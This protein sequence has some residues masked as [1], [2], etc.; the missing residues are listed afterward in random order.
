MSNHFI[1]DVQAGEITL[2]LVDLKLLRGDGQAHVGTGHLVWTA[3]GCRLDAVTDGGSIVWGEFGRFGLT[4]GEI[5]PDDHYLALA[6]RTQDGWR[7]SIERLDNGGYEHHVDQESL[8]WR[9]SDR[10]FRSHLIYEQERSHGDET[11]AAFVVIGSGVDLGTWPR[12]SET[13]VENPVFGRSRQQKDWLQFETSFG[14]VAVRMAESDSIQIRARSVKD[15]QMSDA[16]SAIQKALSYVD[17]RRCEYSAFCE[18]DGKTERRWL[19][20]FKDRSR[21]QRIY[22]PFNG[23]AM[24]T[25]CLEPMLSCLCNFFLTEEGKAIYELLDAWMD[26]TENRFTS[27]VMVEC[28]VVEA[29]ARIICENNPAIGS[30]EQPDEVLSAV[31]DL[32]SHLTAMDLSESTQTRLTGLLG[33]VR[34]RSAKDR[35]YAIQ[36]SGWCGIQQDEIKSWNALRNKV[37]HGNSAVGDGSLP[38][39]QKAVDHSAKIANLINKM[40]LQAAGYAG[41][42][43]DYMTWSTEPFQL[44]AFDNIDK[45]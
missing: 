39:F 25:P 11:A 28:G 36:R 32:K 2:P 26:A 27:R 24:M 22:R 19:K 42:F 21:L 8:I 12:S 10:S 33:T 29:L 40:V 35:L 7:I 31:D 14:P 3:D 13:R 16:R 34:N 38:R 37:M 20:S 6:G 15:C 5:I 4:P 18:Y 45:R 41:Q 23:T 9:M 43:F 44:K 1:S 30:E 17:G